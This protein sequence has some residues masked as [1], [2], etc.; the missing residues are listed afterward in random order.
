ML[1]DKLDLLRMEVDRAA[2]LKKIRLKEL[3]SLL[4]KFSL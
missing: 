2:R 1:E 4:G 3:Q